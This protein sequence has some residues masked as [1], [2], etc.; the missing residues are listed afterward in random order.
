MPN[1]GT[2][3][4]FTLLELLVAFVILSLTVAVLMRSFGQDLRSAT[5]S[6]DYTVATLH[7]E[8]VLAGVGIEQPLT[9]GEQSGQ[10]DDGFQWQVDVQRYQDPTLPP[11]Q[12]RIGI[13]PYR[14][15]VRV[16]WGTSAE[17]HAISLQTLRLSID[18]N[19]S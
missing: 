19:N 5:L 12:H 17:S 9:E 6:R 4:G 15:V 2:Q 10:F 1:S 13:T 3:R 11:D 7:A 18:R 8:S 14:V 16:S